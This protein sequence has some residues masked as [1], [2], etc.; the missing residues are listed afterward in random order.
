M[1]SLDNGVSRIESLTFGNKTMN[2][3]NRG[4][5]DSRKQDRLPS[6]TPNLHQSMV[7]EVSVS[8]NEEDGEIDKII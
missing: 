6:I 2:L 5:P 1:L 3:T 4:H 8:Q 7:K